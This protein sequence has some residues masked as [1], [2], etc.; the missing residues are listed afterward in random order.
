M[1]MLFIV[2]HETE[3]NI[4]QIVMFVPDEYDRKRALSEARENGIP[5]PNILA[6]VDL[7][8][9]QILRILDHVDDYGIYSR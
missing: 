7:P 4:N 9:P 5:Q 2:D 1:K 3:K 6:V 8:E